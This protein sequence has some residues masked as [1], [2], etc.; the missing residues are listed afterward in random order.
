MGKDKKPKPIDFIPPQP[1][2]QNQ[3]PDWGKEEKENQ[4]EEKKWVPYY[5][6]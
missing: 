1:T 6:A 2:D 4:C 3:K 5:Q